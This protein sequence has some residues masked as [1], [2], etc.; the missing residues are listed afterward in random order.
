MKAKEK[1]LGGKRKGKRYI[2]EGGGV[3][4]EREKGEDLPSYQTQETLLFRKREEGPQGNQKLQSRLSLE[5]AS[6]LTRPQ[7]SKKKR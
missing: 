6:A 1:C 2:E 5:G 4:T 3:P 7:M